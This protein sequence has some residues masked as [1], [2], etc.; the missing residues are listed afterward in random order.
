MKIEEVH[1]KELTLW[2]LAKGCTLDEANCLADETIREMEFYKEY[3]AYQNERLENSSFG[4]K[5]EV[6]KRFIRATNEEA[7]LI[8]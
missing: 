7:A 1:D 4:Q 2:F 6:S 8:S 3:Q 5:V